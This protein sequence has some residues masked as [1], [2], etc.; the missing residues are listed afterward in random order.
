MLSSGC[1]P[2]SE[3]L[4][5]VADHVRKFPLRRCSQSEHIDEA[6]AFVTLLLELRASVRLRLCR[7]TLRSDYLVTAPFCARP[8]A[9]N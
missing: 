2:E 8:E 1:G 6:A 4:L 7:T 9:I 3:N 5:V